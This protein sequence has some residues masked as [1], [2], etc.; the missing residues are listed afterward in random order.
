MTHRRPIER[1]RFVSLLETL[2]DDEV[3]EFVEALWSLSGWSVVRS[4]PV[5]EATRSTPVS[6]TR[7]ILV[8]TPS[9][10]ALDDTDL[11]TIDTIVTVDQS[12]DPADHEELE[13]FDPS[14]LYTEA[15]YAI[16]AESADELF[17]SYFDRPARRERNDDVQTLPAPSATEP[18][19]DS[20]TQE[21]SEP[22]NQST[23]DDQSTASASPGSNTNGGP[24]RYALL[25]GLLVMGVLGLG[26][27]AG[28]IPG[29]GPIGPTDGPMQSVAVPGGDREVG[30]EGPFEVP[31]GNVDLGR[32][33][34]TASSHST[35][36]SPTPDEQPAT[37]TPTTTPRSVQS[38][39]Y[40][41]LQP[42]CE[43]PPRLVVAIQVGALRNNNATTN[44]GIATTWRF[45][46]PR[47][48][49]VTG[50]LANFIEIVKSPTYA[51]LLNHTRVTYGPMTISDSVAT[52]PLAVTDQNGTQ[53][54]YEWILVR[55]DSG[56][57]DGCWMTDGVSPINASQV[58]SQNGT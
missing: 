5:L 29:V 35:T 26:I 1:D 13:V 37:V 38:S 48:R 33:S 2:S 16:D 41:G 46:S 47:N 44:D 43:R 36:V 32:Q 56:Q 21:E 11:T 14:D 10:A 27:G 49:E 17:Q 18:T 4:G 28:L 42:T 23:T 30:D 7:R 45:A 50:P 12:V 22:A 20:P 58:L 31:E 55:Q 34:P 8:T 24:W 39:R 6:E 53:H 25:G 52:Q 57:F 54:G 51:P 3:I 19:D 9:T 40:T 15:L